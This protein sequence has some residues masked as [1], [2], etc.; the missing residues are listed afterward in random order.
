[1]GYVSLLA[2]LGIHITPEEW[3]H[4][5]GETP[6]PSH[7]PLLPCR[8]AYYEGSPDD[9]FQMPVFTRSQVDWCDPDHYGF[10]HYEVVEDD[11]AAHPLALSWKDERYYATGSTRRIHR[12][13]RE[14]RLRWTL[15]RLVGWVGRLDSDVEHVLRQ[16]LL[17]HPHV[18]RTRRAYE[19]VRSHLKRLGRRDHYASIAFIIRR[20]GGCRWKVTEAQYR[21]VTDEAVQLHN[22]FN[23]LL[24]QGKLQRMRFPKMQFVLASLLASQGVA[25]PYR[26]LW[27]RTRI[28]RQQ[29]AH[30]LSMLQSPPV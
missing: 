26:M 24:T 7:T 2:E 21:W 8:P 9:A 29:L 25:P 27:A 6:I 15:A 12:Y 4:H 5:H 23:H 18:H 13:S 30:H 11:A 20:L 16:Q 3:A 22:R 19:W 1:M 28:K 17:K 14:Y 10:H